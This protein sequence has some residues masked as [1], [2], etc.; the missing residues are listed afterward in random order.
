MGNQ[1]V[2]RIEF[3]N[4]YEYAIFDDSGCALDPTVS[5]PTREA[6]E[7]ALNFSLNSSKPDP[8]RTYTILFRRTP[9]E[10]K[11]LPADS[12]GSDP[13]TA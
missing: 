13:S 10:W 8:K 5:Y 2:R 11:A 7:S 3:N 1:P 6:A 9:Q 4:K 12:E